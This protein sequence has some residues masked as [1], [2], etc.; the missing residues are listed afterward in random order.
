MTRSLGSCARRRSV[1]SM[2]DEIRRRDVAEPA[3]K[4]ATA[5]PPDDDDKEPDNDDT[6]GKGAT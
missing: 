6:D 4:G 5:P 2:T 1:T 3:G